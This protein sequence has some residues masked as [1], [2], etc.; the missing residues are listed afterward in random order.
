MTGL[1]CG[2]MWNWSDNF[3]FNCVRG[4]E[5]GG[6]EEREVG[7]KG[8]GGEGKEE[9]REGEGRKEGEREKEGGS[10][11]GEREEETKG[12]TEGERERERKGGSLRRKRRGRFPMKTLSLLKVSLTPAPTILVKRDTTISPSKDQY[13]RQAHQI[14]LLHGLRM[15]C[16][17]SSPRHSAK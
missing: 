9:V 14:N 1:D 3:C 12:G 17:S 11:G 7:W 16:G 15:P 6:S 5:E 10:G 4:R 2:K 8:R 13:Y